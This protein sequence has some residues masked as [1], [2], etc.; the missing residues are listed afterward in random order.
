M[1]QL[2]VTHVDLGG[3]TPDVVFLEFSDPDATTD[4][5]IQLVRSNDGSIDLIEDMEIKGE[6]HNIELDVPR[7]SLPDFI[8]SEHSL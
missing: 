6:V 5:T 4:P 2:K 3:D 8:T 7:Q 1:H